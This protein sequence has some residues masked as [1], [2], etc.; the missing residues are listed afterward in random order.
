MSETSKT[1]ESSPKNIYG[2]P[3]KIDIS[4]PEI[5]ELTQNSKCWRDVQLPID[6]LLLTV[7]D[8][9]FLSCYYYINDP[10]R[11]YF[12]ELGPVYLEALVKIKMLN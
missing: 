6:I 1:D 11:S 5:S 8:C 2:D 4:L 3:P 10:F 9:E 12:K 7:K